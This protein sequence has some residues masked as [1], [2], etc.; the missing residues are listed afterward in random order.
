MQTS[1]LPSVSQRAISQRAVFHQPT[2]PR[3]PENKTENS[4]SAR[5]FTKDNFSSVGADASLRSL[6]IAGTGLIR[7]GATQ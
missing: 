1:G 7:R 4:V 2:G 5:P 3:V 6:L